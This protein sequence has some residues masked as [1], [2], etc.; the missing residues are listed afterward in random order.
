MDLVSSQNGNTVLFDR[1]QSDGV[2]AVPEP[3][4]VAVLGVGLAGL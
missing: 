2:S 4:T 3:G 1:I